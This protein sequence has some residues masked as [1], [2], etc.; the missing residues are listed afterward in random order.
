MQPANQSTPSSDY[1]QSG[2]VKS[3]HWHW[4]V[5]FDVWLNN[6]TSGLFLV[7]ACGELF[8]PADFSQL[9]N[10]AYLIAWLVLLVDLLLLVLD[11]GDPKRFHHMLRV[12]KPSSPMSLGTWCL[13]VYSLPLTLLVVFQFIGSPPDGFHRALVI[14]AIPPAFG[15]MLYKGVLF[16]TSSQPGWRD[17]R[18]LGSYLASSTIMLGCIQLLLIAMFFDEPV[19]TRLMR[20]AAATT[21]LLNAITLGLLFFNLKPTLDEMQTSQGVVRVTWSVA[22][23]TSAITFVLIWQPQPFVSMISAGLLLAGTLW[24]RSAVV[25]LPHRIRS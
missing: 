2:I 6:L 4:L 8:R 24:V 25:W 11:L 7:A 9:A 23:A 10:T 18:W 13:T 5:V 14:A 21:I 19:A 16:S 1:A 3:P 12:F 22:F 20:S 15:V 17:A